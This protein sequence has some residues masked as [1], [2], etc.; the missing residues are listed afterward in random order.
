[1]GRTENGDWRDRGWASGRR[2]VITK[3]RTFGMGTACEEMHPK[4]SP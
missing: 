3:A 2:D 4:Y 1:M